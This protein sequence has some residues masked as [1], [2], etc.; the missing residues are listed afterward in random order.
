MKKMLPSTQGGQ[1]LILIA[2]AAIGLF[3]IAGLAIDGSAKFSDRRH[4]QNAADAAALAGALS[5]GAGNDVLTWTF[6]ARESAAE[7][8]Y[9]G[10]VSDTVSVYSCND[11]G[12]S[13]GAYAGSSE[14]VQVII[15]SDVNT[16]F[17]RILGIEETHN[18]V[19]AVALAQESR[20][21]G[22]GAMLISYDP[23]PNCS[24]GGSGGYSVS[25]SGSSTVNLNGGG[26]FVNSDEVCG[27]TIP[28]CADLNIY[29]GSINSA[30]D[31]IDLGSCTFDPPITPNINQD[32]VTIPDDVDMPD[33][34]PECGWSASAYQTGAD[35]WYITPGHYTDFPQ[36]NLNGDKI[37]GNK[38]HL[39]MDPGVYCV[40]G[41]IQWSG[42]T[43]DSLDGSSGVTI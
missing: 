21:L 31:N 2:L 18:T 12:A 3:G 29:G 16:Y 41:N 8:G 34:P 6:K 15:T 17:A 43:F 26:I 33:E 1:A 27:F 13:C 32:P 30:G 36:Y 14:Y 7:N 4:A 19:Q 39:I 28:N 40:S 25:V 9:D 20:V 10:F 24:T 11:P 38:K 37:V 22:D 5:K 35:E 42:N 23:D